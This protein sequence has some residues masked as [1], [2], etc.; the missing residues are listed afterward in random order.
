MADRPAGWGV[1]VTRETGAVEVARRF[2]SAINAHDVEAL[3]ALMTADHVFV[4]SVGDEVRGRDAMC[5]IWER[6]YR[7]FP[8]YRLEVEDVL[9]RADVVGLFGTA[10]GT[11]APEG[12]EGPL[13]PKNR[14]EVPAAWKA[15]VREG[16]TGSSRRPDGPRP[17]TGTD[18]GTRRSDAA[19]AR[20]TAR[21]MTRV[22]GATA[23]AALPLD[24]LGRVGERW[25]LRQRALHR[26]EA[27]P[28]G[29]GERRAMAP[30]FREATLHRARV[31]RT[32]SVARP[33]ID[34]EIAALGLELARM[35]GI[36]YVDTVVVL[37][38]AA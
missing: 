16:R 5:R 4:D 6:Y 3:G 7:L 28:L 32:G 30:F 11:L 26:S 12:A 17:G 35:R 13:D 27:R 36:T 20:P 9:S 2:V 31:V 21:G 10:R 24:L 8:D 38:R 37:D 25:I 34:Q 19:A 1:E 33:R 14:W 29:R 23:G 22:A 18:A 15:V